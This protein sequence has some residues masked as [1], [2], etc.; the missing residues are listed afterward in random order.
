[1]RSS[2][3]LWD[4]LGGSW[5]A[6]SGIGNSKKKKQNPKNFTHGVSEADWELIIEICERGGGKAVKLRGERSEQTLH[7]VPLQR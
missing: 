6:E 2:I 4:H 3:L 5:K 7:H 1:M